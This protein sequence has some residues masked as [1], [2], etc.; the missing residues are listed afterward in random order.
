MHRLPWLAAA[1]LAWSAAAS[2]Q[3]ADVILLRDNTSREGVVLKVT[4]DSVTLRL[5]GSEVTLPLK[6][7]RPDSA[8]LLLRRRLADNDVRGWYDLGEFCQANGLLREALQVFQRVIDLDPSLRPALEPKMEEVRAGDAKAMFDRASALAREEKHEEALRAFS[9][10][11]DKYPASGPAA[12][13]KEE[14]RKLA[15]V[16]QKEN[17][18]R[19]K[20]LAAAQQQVHDQRAK[21]DEAAETQRLA[22]ALR[23][24]DD[25]QKLFNEGLDQEGKGVTGRARKSWEAAVAKIEESRATLLDL[26]TKARTAPVQESAKRELANATRLAIAVYDNLGQMEA[27][28]QNFRDAVRWFNKAI[29]LDPTDRVATELKARIAAEQINRRVRVGN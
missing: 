4:S 16:I 23:V 9:L 20:R 5:Q 25:G 14:L 15:D 13:A 1:M 3:T 22:Q 24:L 17:D 6:D 11:L 28:D 29:A 2:A 8:Y 26:T 7:L 12:Q 21:T 18:D 19:Q 10:L 27:V